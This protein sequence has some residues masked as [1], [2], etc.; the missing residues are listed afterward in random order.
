MTDSR[1]RAD[2]TPRDHAPR[3]ESVRVPGASARSSDTRARSVGHRIGVRPR[4]LASAISGAA[5]LVVLA[6]LR[7]GGLAVSSAP[8]VDDRIVDLAAAVLSGLD[9]TVVLTAVAAL[10]VVPMVRQLPYGIGVV[11][12]CTVGSALTA[13]LIGT[14]GAASIP[15]AGLPNVTVTAVTGFVGAAWSV[16]APRCRPATL[17]LGAVVVATVAGCTVVTG[18]AVPAGVSGA[19]LVA[20]CWWSAC[21]IVMLRSPV[22]A[23]REARNPLDTAAIA[24]RRKLGGL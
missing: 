11:I 2:H 21:S 7:S 5:L 6:L 14:W 4:L 8:V 24:V 19:L 17:G 9:I 13:A 12:A 10:T 20:A 15:A 3:V 22:A 16:A 23:A 18:A 1:G